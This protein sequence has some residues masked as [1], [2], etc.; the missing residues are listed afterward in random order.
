[1]NEVVSCQDMLYNTWLQ[2]IRGYTHK[3]YNFH[4]KV[5]ALRYSTLYHHFL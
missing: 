4:V 3:I 1:M 2:C 5:T